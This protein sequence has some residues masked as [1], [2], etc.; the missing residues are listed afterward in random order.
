MS[1]RQ[2]VNGVDVLVEGEGAEAI[3]M[4]HGWPD[5]LRLWDDQVG[6]LKDR[7]RCVRFTLP[8][9]DP[10][11]PREAHSLDAIIETLKQVIE[12]TCPGEPVTLLLHDWGCFFGYQFAMRH[13]GLVRRIIGVDIGDAGSGAHLR[14]IGAKGRL[15]VFAYQFWLALAWKFGGSPGD[16][17]TRTMARALR[18]P[19]EPSPIGANM[20][21]PYYIRWFGAYG[22][23]RHAR[24]LTLSWPMLYIFG[25]KKPFQFHSSAWLADLRTRKDCEAHEF[26]TGHWVMKARS[27]QFN[28]TVAAWL[29]AT[30][31]PGKPA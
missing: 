8:G 29:E 10:T 12:T 15:M 19:S 26:P 3:V 20:C 13:P 31:N 18:S 22:S 25:G 14:E 5:T 27:A 16:W 21:Y 24:P 7:H 17:M 11:R 30:A 2:H 4:L 6:F 9:F 28:Q 23:Y 1:R